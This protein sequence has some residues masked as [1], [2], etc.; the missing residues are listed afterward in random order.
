MSAWCAVIVV[1]REWLLEP[2][3]GG[4]TLCRGSD[5]VEGTVIVG[6]RDAHDVTVVGIADG[7]V[8]RLFADTG[9]V[10]TSHVRWRLRNEPRTDDIVGQRQRVGVDVE[11]VCLA[12]R[13]PYRYLNHFAE[14]PLAQHSL[15]DC[16]A[17]VRR[18]QH[19]DILAFLNAVEFA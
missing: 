14:T 12:G 10:G 7:C 18:R 15:V 5:H 19:E 3:P 1:H 13:T 11:D 9:N 8:K 2:V 17:P 16:L 4:F 6:T